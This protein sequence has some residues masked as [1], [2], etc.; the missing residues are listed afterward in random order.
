MGT[1]ILMGMIGLAVLLIAAVTWAMNSRKAGE[2]GWVF[3]RYNPRTRGGGSLGLLESIYQPSIEHVIEGPAEIL[4]E[5]RRVLRPDG[6]LF[7]TVPYR[8]PLK[9]PRQALR[10]SRLVRRTSG[11]DLLPAP[12]PYRDGIFMQID[13]DGFYQYEFTRSQLRATLDAWRREQVRRETGSSWPA[14]PDLN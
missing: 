11:R 4:A 2:R 7:V 5:F 9:R 6:T 8:S 1:V 13:A 12:V 3:N 10:N 14:P